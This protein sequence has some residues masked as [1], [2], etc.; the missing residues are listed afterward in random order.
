MMKLIRCVLGPEQLQAFMDNMS[1]LI[2]GM[3]AWETR[4]HDKD[5]L[6]TVSYRGVEYQVGSASMTV[7]IVIDESW[8]DDFVRKVADADRLE[9][10]SIR[11]LYVVQVEQ[12]FH[13]RNGFMDV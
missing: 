2:V 6:Q 3:T 12:S 11:R 7:D 9:Q 10:F 1:N 13:I 8:V 4:Q 5:N